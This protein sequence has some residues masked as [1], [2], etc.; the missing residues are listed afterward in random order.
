[1]EKNKKLTRES[2][3][4]ESDFQKVANK[5]ST[6][7]IIGNVMLYVVKLLAGI[8]AHSSARN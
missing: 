2:N 1:M 6:V 8:I 7:T 5:V 3:A 4:A